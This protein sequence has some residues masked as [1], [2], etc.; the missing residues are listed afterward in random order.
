MSI[1]LESL[2]LFRMPSEEHV[3]QE[4]II[5]ILTVNCTGVGVGGLRRRILIIA[6]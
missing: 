1:T 6:L 3:I 2:A 5:R 4:V